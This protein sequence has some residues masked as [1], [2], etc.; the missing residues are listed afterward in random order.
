M[1]ELPEAVV[2]SISDLQSDG[3]ILHHSVAWNPEAWRAVPLSSTNAFLE[4]AVD[5]TVSHPG[6]ISRNDVIALGATDERL[7]LG[8]MVFGFGPVGYG[9]HRVGEMVTK[10]GPTFAER[11]AAITAAGALGPAESWDAIRSSASRVTGLGIAFGTKVTYFASLRDSP[12]K[13][14]SLIADINTSWGAWEAFK[15]PRSVEQKGSY[16]AYVEMARSFEASGFRPDEVE[17]GLFRY[18]QQVLAKRRN[19]A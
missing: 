19:G 4:D 16:L 14:V 5:L 8:A 9:P 15:I 3:S 10:T 7:F 13:P 12:E 2:R 17:Y 1:A 11:L 18:G 6:R